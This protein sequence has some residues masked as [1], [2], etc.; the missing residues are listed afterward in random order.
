MAAVV[1][2]SKWSTASDIW[3]AKVQ[4]D[5]GKGG[6][7]A[8]QLGHRLQPVIGQ[9]AAE[10]CVLDITGEEQPFL[11]KVE[12]WASATVDYIAETR[13][14]QPRIVECKATRDYPWDDIPDYYKTQLAWQCWTSGIPEATLAVLHA[15][16]SFKV[17]QFVLERDGGDWFAETVKACR[18]FWFEHVLTGIKPEGF[19]ADPET[20]SQIRAIKGKTVEMPAAYQADFNQLLDIR[21]RIKDLEQAE[22]RL[23]AKFQT[24][25]GDGEVLLHKNQPV[26]TWKESESNRLD[27][28]ALKK[29]EPELYAKYTKTSASRRFLVREPKD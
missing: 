11:H 10:L 15:S 4:G 19:A 17:Y 6:S 21:S 25:L 18:R 29:A 23:K 3:A 28:T 1:G 12:N 27:S 24:L 7:M 8:T 20:L 5:R 14:G 13:E 9:L 26:I 16:T 2:L 22:E